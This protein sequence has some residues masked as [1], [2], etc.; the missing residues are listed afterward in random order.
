MA[1]IQKKLLAWCAVA[2][3]LLL[4]ANVLVA[5][6]HLGGRAGQAYRW[7]CR[8]SGAELSYRPAVFGSARLAPGRAA[9]GGGR[10]WELVEP[11]PPS[12]LRPW[13]WLA[14]LLDRPAPDPETVVRQE[15]LAAD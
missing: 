1:A 13:N 10:R 4:I 14:L 11:R 9:Q 7:V 15:K 2:A 12:A 3:S 6:R 5:V 8:D